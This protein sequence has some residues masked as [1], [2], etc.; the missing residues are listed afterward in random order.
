MSVYRSKRYDDCAFGKAPI[1]KKDV[2][3]LNIAPAIPG[4]DVSGVGT[5]KTFVTTKDKIAFMKPVLF[6]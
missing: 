5:R 4:M 2:P 1:R 6:S 3:V